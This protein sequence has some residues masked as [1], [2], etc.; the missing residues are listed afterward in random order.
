MALNYIPV[1]KIGD[2]VKCI[3]DLFDHYQYFWDQE[4]TTG[5]PFHGIVVVIQDN[6]LLD[7]EICEYGYDKLYIV[8]C[9]DGHMRF[10]AHWE[11]RLVSTSS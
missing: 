10:F 3:Y 6:I 8:R 5:Y 4:A 2:L 11:M 1:Y 7:K 9:F